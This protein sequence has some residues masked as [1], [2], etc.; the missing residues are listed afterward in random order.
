MGIQIMVAH[1]RHFADAGSGELVVEDAFGGIVQVVE[2]TGAYRQHEE[3]G[4]DRA[5]QNGD[6]E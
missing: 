1:N 5:K 3:H 4:E 2:L 6:R